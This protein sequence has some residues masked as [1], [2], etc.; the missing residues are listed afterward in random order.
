MCHRVDLE[1]GMEL[2]PTNNHP[3]CLKA[4]TNGLGSQLRQWTIYYS[5]NW[6]KFIGDVHVVNQQ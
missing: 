2:K 1:R 3:I 4:V 5:A 6:S